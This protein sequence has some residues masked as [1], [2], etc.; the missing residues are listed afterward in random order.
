MLAICALVRRALALVL[1]PSAQRLDVAGRRP[2]LR[3][4]SFDR[5]PLRRRPAPRRRRRRRRGAGVGAPASGSVSFAGTRAGQAARRH[6]R[7]GRRLLGDAHPA[8]LD[9]SSRGR[10]G[11]RGRGVGT[12]GPS[13]RS[14]DARAARPPRRPPHDDQN[15]YVDPLSL[16][17]RGPV[18]ASSRVGRTAADGRRAAGREAAGAGRTGRARWRLPRCQPPVARRAG[19]ARRSRRSR[20]RAPRPAAAARSGEPSRSLLRRPRSRPLRRPRSTARRPFSRCTARAVRSDAVATESASAA[21]VS[22]HGT[23]GTARRAIEPRLASRRGRRR[24]GRVIRRQRERSRGARRHALHL[25]P[26]RARSIESRVAAC[27]DAARRRRR[28]A[29]TAAA[30]PTARARPTGS[31]GG[32][33]SRLL[34]PSRGAVAL[35]AARI[36]TARVR[37]SSRPAEDPGGAGLA[38]R[39]RAAPHRP[40]GGLRGPADIFAR[41]HRLR[42]N[43]VLMVSGTDEH[44]TPVMVVGRSGRASRRVRSP[45]TTTSSSARTS[46]TSGISYDLF[47]RTTTRN[48][49]RV[50]AGPLPTLYEHGCVV[51]R[52]TLGAFSPTT[53][54]TLPDRYI[55]GTCP[56]CGYAEARGDQCDNCGNQLDP[57]DLIEPALEDRR[58][59]A[60]VPRDE[61]PLPRPA[62]SSPTAC[63]SGSRRRRTGGRTS[64]TSRSR[65]STSS[66]RAP[67]TRDLDWGVP[68]PVEGYA[69]DENKR[70][71]VWFDAVIG[72]LSAAVEWAREPGRARRLARVVAEPRGART[73][74]SWARTTSSSTR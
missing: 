2:V 56:I 60:R 44:G 17:P 68:I 67:I 19:T 8:R 59:D 10:R 36:M 1:A 5:R 4:F 46:A 22:S 9:R 38:V 49:E 69:E 26:L 41:Y 18:G 23:V 42:G 16:L 15:G 20:P 29:R 45:T 31:P 74:T 70:I 64:R 63:A 35:G 55:E 71:Y 57:T 33:S 12:V 72:Y 27:S 3:P 62:R 39:E 53:G 11:R 6:D 30:S 58:V 66:S 50:V 54:H 21:D 61:A 52:T 65:S 25:A 51:E 73:T 43:D 7:D 47:T 34:R 24:T 28:A 37:V 48:H 32:G 40:R 14:G 13:E